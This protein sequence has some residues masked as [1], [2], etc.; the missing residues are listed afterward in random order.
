MNDSYGIRKPGLWKK[1]AISKD[2]I[3]L[4]KDEKKTIRLIKRKIKK[5]EKK[6]LD[7]LNAWWFGEK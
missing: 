3:T 5:A 2:A 4:S 7:D 6:L 1:I